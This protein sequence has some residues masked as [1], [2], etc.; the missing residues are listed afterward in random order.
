MH[1]ITLRARLLVCA[2]A[3]I[4]PESKS[5]MHSSATIVTRHYTR[6]AASLSTM[7]LNYLETVQTWR[8]A[9]NL[10]DENIQHYLQS[11]INLGSIPSDMIEAVSFTET[12]GDGIWHE[13]NDS[14]QAA[15]SRIQTLQTVATKLCLI[16]NRSPSLAPISKLPPEILAHIFHLCVC[17]PRAGW[18][19]GFLCAPYPVIS[20]GTF[21]KRRLSAHRE[22]HCA[23]LF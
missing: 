17:K 5:L 20:P 22:I 18:G 6:S 23:S 7:P 13:I 14:V 15:S 10:L 4:Y 16:R 12:T 11:V 19:S 8:S 21:F 1:L 3:L 2:Q 9:Q